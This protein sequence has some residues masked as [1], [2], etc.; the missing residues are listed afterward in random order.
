MPKTD[1]TN[2]QTSHLSERKT[3]LIQSVQCSTNHNTDIEDFNTYC[4]FTSGQML[5][6]KVRVK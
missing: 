4:T 2:N 1:Q 3:L 5:V 6:I